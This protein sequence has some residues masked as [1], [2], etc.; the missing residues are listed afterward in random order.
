MVGIIVHTIRENVE[1]KL[2]HTKGLPNPSSQ[3]PGPQLRA[4]LDSYVL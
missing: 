3:L 4:P 2:D 1:G